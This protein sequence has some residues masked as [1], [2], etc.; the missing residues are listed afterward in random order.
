MDT[1]LHS[2]EAAGRLPAA[3]L[4]GKAASVLR[5]SALAGLRLPRSWVLGARALEHFVAASFSQ[6]ERAQLW[7][8]LLDP[9]ARN[10]VFARL[11]HAPMPAAIRREV[12]QA[13]D[14]L[15]VVIVRSSG[16]NE[17]SAATSLAGH[18][19]SLVTRTEPDDLLRVIKSCWL[20]GLRVYFDYLHREGSPPEQSL[21]SL[22][23]L[24]QE[25][26][27]ARASGVYFTQSPLDPGRAMAVACP[28]TCHSVVDGRLATDLFVLDDGRV[29]REELRH[30]FEMTVV[31]PDPESLWAG[32]TIHTPCGPA[33]YHLPYGHLI[34]AA[35]V[36]EPLDDAPTLTRQELA[37]LAATASRV[38]NLLGYEVDMEWSF[39]GH[40]LVVLQARPITTAPPTVSA[41]HLDTDY[42]VASPGVAEGPVRIVRSSDDIARV[43]QGDVMVVTVT[44]PDYMPA[45]YRAVAV[46]AEEG[47]PLSHTAIVARELGIPCLTGV[48]GATLGQFREGEVIRVDANQGRILR[49]DQSLEGPPAAQP[50]PSPVAYRADRLRAPGGGAPCRVAASALLHGFFER[51]DGADPSP[52]A[53]G[54]YLR[55]LG[56]PA[57]L[58]VHWDV[59]DLGEPL[60][61]ALQAALSGR[62]RQ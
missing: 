21:R 61:A 60:I 53:M 40:G 34:G 38:R 46:V 23:L 24:V 3:E 51:S 42:S 43:Q 18:Y 30:K 48:R 11:A 37:E 10:L 20:S 47:S 19:E 1:F 39:D 32:Q 26:I 9:A 12:L 45:F 16:T 14:G 55:R 8:G 22:G 5:L 17:D 33:T 52:V 31:T 54:E 2:L 15:K 59:M 62:T 29:D 44:D 25:V 36:P 6:Q 57:R 27:D 49:P 56:G 28:G 50:A 4:G 58:D 35:R 13:V 41:P 7:N